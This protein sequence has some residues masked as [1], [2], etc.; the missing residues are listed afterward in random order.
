M[1]NP[2][3][4]YKKGFHLRSGVANPTPDGDGGNL[5]FLNARQVA[6][7]SEIKKR[8]AASNHPTDVNFPPH[9]Y[10]P[11]GAQSLDLRRVV[12]ISSPSSN[13]LLF[14]FTCPPGAITRFIKYGIFNDGQNGAN[15]DFL[16]LVDKGRIFPYHGDPTQNYKI[17]L[18]VGP[19]L[20]ESSMIPC[21]LSLQPGQTLEW[22]I[23][24]SSGVNTSMGVRMVGYFDTT[25]KR[26]QGR[27]GG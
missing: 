23:S 1:T 13:V 9:L 10:I 15:Y 11:Q 16:P 18:G 3:D 8:E 21:Q 25:Q 6:D 14:S 2:F 26:V 19:D 17:Y 4:S 5:D 12:S 24:N 22:Y 7:K 20:S 27:F